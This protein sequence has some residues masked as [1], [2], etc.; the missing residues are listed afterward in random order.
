MQKT[1]KKKKSK[2]NV[3]TNS[4]TQKKSDNFKI[5]NESASHARENSAPIKPDEDGAFP[6]VGMGASAGGLDALEKIFSNMPYDSGMAFVIVMHFDPKA[7]SVMADILKR[8]TKME[9][10]QVEDGMKVEPN[11]V[12][13]I[14]PNRDMAILRKMLHLYEPVVSKGIR[15]PVDFFFRSLADDQKENAICIILSGTGT[16]GTLGLKAIKGEGGMVMVESLESAA[17]DGMPGSAI[18]TGLADYILPPEKMPEQ[19]VSYVKQFYAGKITEPERELRRTQS[20][21]EEARNRFSNLYDFAPSGYFT[22]DNNGLILEVNLTGANKLGIERSLLIKKPFSLYINFS[23]RDI[24][25]L[26]LRN[27][28]KTG[29][30]QTCEI[31]LLDKNKNQFDAQLES[32]AVQDSKG[33]FSQC[34]TAII[35]I[36]ERKRAQEANSLLASIVEYS[37]DA[38]IGKTLDGT[39][40]S[41]NTGAQKTYGYTSNEVIGKPISI[42]VPPAKTDEVPKIL[43]RVRKGLRIEHYE[44]VRMRKDGKQIDVSLTISPIKDST[45]KIIGAST[46]ARDITEHKKAEEAIRE[47]EE[48]YRNLVESAND[49]IAMVSP[50]GIIISLNLAFERITGWSREEWVGKSFP[51]LIH[52]DDFSKAMEVFQH[53]MSGETMPGSELRLLASSGGYIDVEYV[54][55]PL[56]KDGKVI[57]NLNV[58]RDITERKRAGEKIREQAALLDK[59]R[60]AIALRNLEHDLIYWNKGAE[61][62]YGWTAEEVIGKNADELLYKGKP[63][64]LIEAENSVIDKGEWIGEL[65]QIT[66]E[67][68]EIIVQSRWTLVRDREGKPKSI[69]IINTDITET[70]KLESQLLRAQRIESIGTLAGGIAHDLNNMLTPIM[71]SLQ[72]L[73]EKYKDEQSQKLLTILENNSQRGADLIKQV[74]SF[75]RGVE[76]ERTPLQAKH[77]INEIE[78][79]AKE[80]FPRNIEI[81]TDIK[82]DLLAIS[83][84]ATQLNQVIM[85][86]AVNA[87][88]AMHD[89]G[90]L[91]ISAENFLIDEN[92]VRMNADAKVCP[93]VLITVSD[94]GTGIPPKIIDRIFEPFFT[95]KEFGKGT[96]LGLSTAL[97][98]VK[99]HGGFINVYSEVGKGTAFRVYLPAI[100]TEM[101]EACEQQPE[102]LAGNGEWILV[103]EDEESIRDVTFSTLEMNGYKA[104]TA[105]D[106]AEA[107]AVYAENTDKIKIILMDMMM[108][109]MDGPASIR[110]IRRVN[111]EVKIIAVS[112]LTEK[113]RLAKVADY[114]NA[115]LPKPY[116]AERLLKTIHKVLNAK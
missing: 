112:G 70:K 37:D 15:H 79:V 110:A 95:T 14:P 100:K 49:I 45:V 62:L 116:T 26:H 29:T 43:Q 61:F 6:I 16:E 104:L 40:L 42:L 54:T 44:T 25:Y 7:K 92:Y 34:S 55:T 64:K 10:S 47:S 111:P 50:D 4:A 27:V 20:E 9:V 89:G 57:G 82:K 21:L 65:G 31:K 33:N 101:H 22:F 80:T 11:R 113:D 12:Y 32:L 115:F 73:K 8:Y 66:K 52:P 67:G 36:T 63:A 35:D 108:P 53:T 105:N 75:A 3:G 94:T 5:T 69:L 48:R 99:S 97:A 90:V 58:V 83:G 109:I 28:F 23:G 81:R 85:N 87:R 72:I 19:L 91:S 41:W 78:K 24:F 76:G 59:A 39:I 86:L 77:I 71:L 18:G 60:D 107:V 38:I 68:K 13:I 88:D 93:C 2:N 102:L 17:Y 96:G 1:G 103:A 106:G 98:I 114:T 84:D 56:L 46:I 30:R 74:L 51:P